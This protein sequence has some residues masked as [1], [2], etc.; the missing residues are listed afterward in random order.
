[1]SLSLPLKKGLYAITGENGIGKST[2]FAAL[3]KLV[4]RGALQNFFKNDG[5]ATSKI[6]YRSGG[7]EN[8]WEKKISWQRTDQ[9]Q[10]EICVDGFY[11]GSL[12]FGNRFSDAHIS[13]VSKAIKISPA[14]LRDSDPFVSENLGWILRND[15]SHFSGLKRVKSKPVAEGLGFHGIPYL[16]ER[17]GK[18]LHYLK[19][20]SGEFLLI[21]LLHLINERVKYKE[22]KQNDHLSVIIMDEIELALHPSAQDR[23]AIFLNKISDQHNFCIYFATHSVQIIANVRPEKI[24]HLESPTAGVI[25]VLN[26]CYPAYATRCLYTADGFD[27]IL[28]VEDDLAKF[29]V[30]G[31]LREKSMYSS[32]LIKI[33]PCGGWEKT[34]ELQHEISQSRLAG[35][36]CKVISILDG[37]IRGECDKLYG[38]GTQYGALPKQFLPI[39]SLEKYLLK[40]LALDLD[41]AFMRKFGDEFFQVRSLSDIMNDYKSDK[42]SSS[43]SNG[44]GLFSV[45]KRCASEQGIADEIFKRDVCRF[46]Y[47]YEDLSKLKESIKRLC[48]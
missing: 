30:E 37:D 22:K 13:R 20:S 26:P 1:M 2:I 3:S 42:R 41:V 40:K 12:I 46:I 33:L 14:D 28:L 43:D 44:K 29:L 47:D 9:C 25:E 5:E 32:R 19:M 8:V 23:L 10:S 35:N 39:K 34:L 24:F 48:S 36:A 15:K 4:Y 7:D 27:Y 6:S 18:W 45:L 21:G 31:C 11:E 38:N 16:I 17:N